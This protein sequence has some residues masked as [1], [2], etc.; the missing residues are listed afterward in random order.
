MD[1]RQQ[2]GGTG[3]APNRQEFLCDM[4]CSCFESDGG[5]VFRAPSWEPAP[6]TRTVALRV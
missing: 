2:L 6:G 3:Q 1:G 4:A 5:P